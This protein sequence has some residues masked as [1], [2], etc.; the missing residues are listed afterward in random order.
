LCGITVVVEGELLLYS[1]FVAL[2]VAVMVVHLC[3]SC[4]RKTA[5]S[6]A[7]ATS[8]ESFVEVHTAA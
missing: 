1:V 6:F 8:D 5:V 7:T 3:C 2:V 4:G